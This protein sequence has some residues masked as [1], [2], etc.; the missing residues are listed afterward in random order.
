MTPEAKAREI[1]REWYVSFAD[2]KN[3][4]RFFSANMRADFVEKQ[5]VQALRDV[6]RETLERAANVAE[7]YD[8]SERSELIAQS[9]RALINSGR[10]G[11]I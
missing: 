6:E 7:N 5:I 3:D 8:N 10:E 9:I 1:A 4:I 2:P 11:E